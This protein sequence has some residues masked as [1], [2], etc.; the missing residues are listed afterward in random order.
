MLY[1]LYP[2]VWVAR[3]VQLNKLNSMVK[4]VSAFWE[5]KKLLS[6]VSDMGLAIPVHATASS[7]SSDKAVHPEPSLLAYIAF[8]K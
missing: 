3:I 5:R 2:L 8:C 6:E 1:K 4:S 7:E